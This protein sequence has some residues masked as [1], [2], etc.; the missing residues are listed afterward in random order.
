MQLTLP[1]VVSSVIPTGLLLER[2]FVVEYFADPPDSRL[3]LRFGC[4][5]DHG[6]ESA[7][8]GTGGITGE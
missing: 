3:R 6:F 5:L 7:I 2:T 4:E 8:L 1:S